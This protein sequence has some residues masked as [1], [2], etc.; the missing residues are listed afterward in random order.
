M[1]PLSCFA[2]DGLR[3]CGAMLWVVTNGCRLI[4]ETH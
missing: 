4:A 3:M 1:K 2:H